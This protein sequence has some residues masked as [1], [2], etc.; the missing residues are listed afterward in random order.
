MSSSCPVRAR[1]RSDVAVEQLPPGACAHPCSGVP[2]MS[3]GCPW[4][5]TCAC[6]C[7]VCC[8]AWTRRH[9]V[10]GV[11]A[12][13]PRCGPLGRPPHPAS[14]TS[15]PWVVLSAPRPRAQQHSEAS[16]CSVRKS[17]L[18]LPYFKYHHSRTTTSPTRWSSSDAA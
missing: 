13:L 10:G 1:A 15:H 17:F 9:V 16:N 5:R 14:A 11:A 18:V 8:R 4:A 6:P 3:R 7:C 2:W 12:E